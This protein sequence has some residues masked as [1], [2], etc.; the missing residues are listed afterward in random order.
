MLPVLAPLVGE[1]RLLL[2]GLLLSV[3]EQAWLAVIG[4]KSQAFGAIAVGALAGVAYPAIS[5]MKANLCGAEQQGL[6]QGALAGIRA[7][8]S[9]LG[10]VA[11]AQLFALSTKTTSEFGYH[12]G[13]V[14][15]VSGGITFLAV[16]VAATISKA[17]TLGQG[18]G[19]RGGS[20]G[21]TALPHTEGCPEDLD[22]VKEEEVAFLQ[23]D[24]MA[25]TIRVV[26]EGGRE[27]LGSMI[28]REGQVGA[29][30]GHME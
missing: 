12:P 28:I 5:S 2:G 8:A 10:P 15:W 14:F 9:G 21:Y 13:L 6:V 4:T 26:G 11:F 3:T 23:K 18:A 24:G 27:R 1:H 19:G 29:P 16:I 7:L 25:V 22:C 17:D 30:A 20:S